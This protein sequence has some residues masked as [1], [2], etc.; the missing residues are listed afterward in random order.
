MPMIKLILAVLSAA[1][2]ASAQ[3]PAQT[4]DAA[5]AKNWRVVQKV[6]GVCHTPESVISPRS[7][8][9][10]Q[11]TIDKMV[12]TQG[13]KGTPEEFATVL[14]YLSMYYGPNSTGRGAAGGR[15][16]GGRGEG[17]R[18]GG[19]GMLA[20]AGPSDKPVVDPV[21][22]ERGAKI[23]A[24]ECIDCHG[25]WAR[26]TDK[27]P[28]LIRSVLVLH[29]R[30]GDHIGP[31]LRKGHPLQSGA[32]G[33]TLTDA[34]IVELSH[35]IYQRVYDTLRGS[36]IFVMHDI[37]TGDAAAGKTYFNGAGRC[38]TCH[39]P[40]GDLAHIGS[41][42]DPPTLQARFLNPRPMA[43]RGG[44]GA[45]AGPADPN[46]KKVTLTVTPRGGPSV[47]GAPVVFDDFD[48]AVRDANG[49]YHAWKRTTD[50]KV[51]KN[52][53]YAVHDELI[54][55][56]TNKNMHDILAYLVTLK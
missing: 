27:G 13:A 15:G 24:A 50:L 21:A 55:E 39:S 20:G 32:R 18:G 53:P 3:K 43:G 22:A 45:A 41:K 37:L 8:E 30:Y 12:T 46:A 56:Y 5:Q 33:D 4:Q 51:V 40:T 31:F 28:N 2:L 1:L 34:Q 42:Y 36:P 44:R 48:V 54:T 19:G 23:W 52:D 9:Q 11:E 26:G 25:T 7:R 17:G 38:S 49:E 47:T 14:D 35:F 6:C 10:W 29:D 16:A